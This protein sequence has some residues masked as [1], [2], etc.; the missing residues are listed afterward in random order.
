MSV[1]SIK[2]VAFKGVVE[3]LGA[4]RACGGVS[5]AELEASLTEADLAYL[6][7]QISPGFWYPMESYDRML[8]V[9][10]AKEGAPDGVAYLHARGERAMKRMVDMGLYRQFETMKE[11]WVGRVG[12][13]MTS[14]GGAVYNFASWEF[15]RPDDEVAAAREFTI[16]LTEAEPLNDHALH[17]IEGAVAMLAARAAAGPVDVTSE[18]PSRDHIR[19]EAKRR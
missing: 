6:E 17:T 3:D 1:P 13:A 14:L 9:L 19:I 16:E 8:G 11:G 18:R 7:E 5:D 10:V 15:V 4:L 2:G 12:N